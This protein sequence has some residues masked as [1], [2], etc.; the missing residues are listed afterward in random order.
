M[1]IINMKRLVTKNEDK[2]YP[3]LYFEIFI[4]RKPKNIKIKIIVVFAYSDN[5]NKSSIDWKEVK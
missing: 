1:D 2:K 3:E 4:K 5:M